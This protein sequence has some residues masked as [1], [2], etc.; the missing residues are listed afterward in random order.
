MIRKPLLLFMMAAAASWIVLAAVPVCSDD[1]EMVES[2][3]LVNGNEAAHA[4]GVL[5]AI[6][7][8]Q[9]INLDLPRLWANMT[10][11]GVKQAVDGMQAETSDMGSVLAC[12]PLLASPTTAATGSA[13]ACP[14]L[15]S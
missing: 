1:T 14:L 6:P 13:L 8:N 5:S 11:S 4:S 15:L 2:A 10:D 9:E 3:M 12:S 7:V